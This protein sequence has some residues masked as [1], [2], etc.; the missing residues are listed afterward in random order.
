MARRIISSKTLEQAKMLFIEGHTTTTVSRSLGI[1]WT[2]ARN[3]ASKYQPVQCRCGKKINH[4]GICLTSLE[5]KPSDSLEK[6]TAFN[7]VTTNFTAV[8]PDGSSGKCI[9]DLAC[10]FPAVNNFRCRQ[11]AIDSRLSF[12]FLS[13]TLVPLDSFLYPERHRTSRRSACK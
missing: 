10:P 12:S 5:A 2:F 7:L 8:V 4:R 3:L 13:S 6:T 11:H 9:G 1:S